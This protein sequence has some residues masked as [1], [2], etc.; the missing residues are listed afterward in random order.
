MAKL[1]DK[2]Y[3]RIIEGKLELENG[4]DIKVKTSELEDSATNAG[5]VLAI[6]ENGKVIATEVSGGTKIYKHQFYMNL[7]S[8]KGVGGI[9]ITNNNE[10]FEVYE[11]PVYMGG[12]YGIKIKGVILSILSVSTTASSVVVVQPK[13]ELFI[14]DNYSIKAIA[15]ESNTITNTNYD[16]IS[17]LSPTMANIN[18]TVTEL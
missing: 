12:G 1:K 18:D 2:L 5:K 9:I 11:V 17:S 8:A 10:P 7:G 14:E 4:D 6:D 15:I 16:L 3:N 13:F